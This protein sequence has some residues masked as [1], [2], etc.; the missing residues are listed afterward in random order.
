[1]DTVQAGTPVLA[2]RTAEDPAKVQAPSPTLDLPRPNSHRLSSTQQVERRPST[3]SINRKSYVPTIPSP[4]NPSTSTTSVSSTSDDAKNVFMGSTSPRDS[5]SSAEIPSTGSGNTQNGVHEKSGK[6][7][8]ST[9]QQ[10]L[11][12]KSALI[13]LQLEEAQRPRFLSDL[14]RDYSRYPRSQ[15]SLISR[16]SGSVVPLLSPRM[17]DVSLPMTER[18]PF[19]DSIASHGNPEKRSY[20]DDSIGAFD[21]YYGGEKGFILYHDEIEDDDDLHMPRDDDDKRFKTSW[22]DRLERRTLLSSI[23]GVILVIGLLCLFV[24]LPVLT[25]STTLY[26]GAS[27]ND[28]TYIDYGPAWAHI[29]NVRKF[30]PFI[31]LLGSYFLDLVCPSTFLHMASV[32]T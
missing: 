14:G 23:G 26:P 12:Q 8:L 2:S 18:N 17:S 22:S 13:G 30:L 21:P 28:S 20:P 19:R 5:S 7:N 4:L 32:L 10:L 9:P 1:M 29:N 24:L 31:L 6:S 16:G 3:L 27:Y 11:R 15:S 25:F